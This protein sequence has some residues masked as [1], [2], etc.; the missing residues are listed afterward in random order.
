MIELTQ[1]K[2]NKITLSDYNYRRDIENRL[3]LSSFTAFEIAVL[4]EIL[5]SSIKAPIRKIAKNIEKTEEEIFPILEILSKTG[6]LTI[7]GDSIIVD[8]E[9]RKYFE[10]EIEKFAPDFCPGMEFLQNILK[11]V[12]IHALPIWYS[13][14]RTSNNIFESLV[15]KYLLTPQIFQRYLLELTFGDPT[16]SAIAQDVFRSPTLT[17]SAKD[18]MKKYELTREK[19]EE[20]MLILELHFVCC[21]KFQPRG[22][23]WEETV[24]PF[25]E[26]RE[27]LT[28]LKATT[29]QPI[30]DSA[31]IERFRL[32]D[33]AFIEDMT[34]VLQ[35]VKKQPVPLNPKGYA[36][37]AARLQESPPD[38]TY[39]DQVINKL[40]LL[41]LAE[42][43]DDKLQPT[44]TSAEW[45]EMRVENRAL[46]LYRH[47]LN[48]IQSVQLPPH[49]ITEKV[50]HDAEKAI[51]RVLHTGWIFYDEFE[52]GVIVPFAEHSAATLKKC[53][54]GWK[55]ALPEYSP[56]E[57]A[58]IYAIVFEWLFEAGITAVGTSQGR[59]CFTV[60]PF[61]QSLFG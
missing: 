29:T 51:L 55:Y 11:K 19:F 18:V 13:I 30:N 6:L 49:L 40:Q 24:T 54:K 46:Y 42:T 38:P 60:T 8:K 21:L 5:Y 22:S 43:V 32:H 31:K 45:L 37:I 44:E 17:L 14:P 7:E 3:L 48:K 28:F 57:K 36:A 9:T 25:Y 59:D 50:I 20:N 34:A 15:E 26:W 58:L 33:F 52:K 35:L 23:G 4:E 1:V 10:T 47:A 61:G 53:G 41:K 2:K 16:L 12:P 56:D 39:I 27:Y